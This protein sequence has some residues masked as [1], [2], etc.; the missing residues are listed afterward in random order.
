MRQWILSFAALALVAAPALAGKYNKV[1]SVGDKA[2]STTAIPA[3]SA[4]GT[5]EMQ[6]NLA[7]AKEDVVVVAFLANHCPAVKAVEDRLFDLVKSY[8]GKNVKFIGVCSSGPDMAD[9]D[10]IAG[11]KKAIADGKY[12]I[13]YG[14]DEDGKIGKAF[15]ATNTPQFF[16]LDKDRSIRYTGTLDD[17]TMDESKVGKKYVMMAVDSLLA[18]PKATI[19]VTETRAQGC[20]IPYKR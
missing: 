7:D 9:E 18:D 5:K 2:P 12:N 16:V 4:D 19:E 6:L 3:V 14:Y 8:K 20:G 11:I 17:S 1:V 15:G 13:A 10:G